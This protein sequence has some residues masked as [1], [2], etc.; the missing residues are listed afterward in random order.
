MTTQ[1]PERLRAL[2]DD[3]PAALSAGDLWQAGRR[4]HRSRLA[5]AALVAGCLVGAVS[6]LGVGDWHSRRAEPSS[7]PATNSGPLAIPRPLFNPSPW[8]SATS[9]PGRLV[10]LL[11]TTRDHFPLGSDRNGLVGVS[12]GAQAYHF[13]D[14]PGRS[15]DASAPELSPDG[16]HVA[17]WVNGAPSGAAQLGDRSILGVAVLDLVT[18]SV[19]RHLIATV[20]GLSA[21]LLTWADSSRLVMVADQFSSS[22]VLSYGGRPHAYEFTLGEGSSY[23]RLVGAPWPTPMTSSEGFAAMLSGRSLR[24]W[25]PGNDRHTDLRLSEP[26]R[27]GAFDSGSHRL[28]A[29]SGNPNNSGR[30]SEVL[31]VG[32]AS[33]GRVQLT[34]VPGGRRYAGV[35]TWVDPRHVAVVHQT[36]RGIDYEVVDVRTGAHRELT[37]KPWFGFTIARDALHQAN[38]VPGIEPPRPWNPRWVAG[39]ALGGLLLLGGV[40]LA[41]VVRSRRVRR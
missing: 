29:V 8:L 33:D 5:T 19:E 39:G 26:I 6:V 23:T 20:H 15:P 34:E 9:S 38:V 41:L 16:L 24:T 21:D 37:R 40:T 18:G 1:L 10:A 35:E 4:R 36:R 11:S 27:S 17:Y 22:K 25:S 32:R 2:A 3:A 12:A 14:L 30:T 31:V 7:P 13:L 28:A